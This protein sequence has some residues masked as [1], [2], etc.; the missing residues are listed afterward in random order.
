MLICII[1]KA[2]DYSF[3]KHQANS[4]FQGMLLSLG[5]QNWTE[6]TN[7]FPQESYILEKYLRLETLSSSSCIC[8]VY[9]G[10]WLIAVAQ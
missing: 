2:L 1:E 3:Y 9:Y 6:P 7:I 10:A 8:N 4:A 5:V